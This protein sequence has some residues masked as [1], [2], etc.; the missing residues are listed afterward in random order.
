MDETIPDFTETE[1]TIVQETVDQRF[2]QSITLMMADSEIRLR[3]SD[4]EL[5]LC[6]AIV[7]EE[8][9]TTFALFKT[10]IRYFRCQFHYRKYQQYGTG[11]KEF[12]DIGDCII[13]LLQVHADY[14]RE[15]ESSK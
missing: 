6:P 12:T 3:P 4:R 7:F 11:H 5:A 10:S 2:N 13:T 15:H 9:D 14:E 1:I 8:G